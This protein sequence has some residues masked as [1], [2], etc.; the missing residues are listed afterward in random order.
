MSISNKCVDDESSPPA[1]EEGEVKSDAEAEEI[2]ETDLDSLKRELSNEISDLEWEFRQ[3]KEALYAERIAQVDKKLQQLKSSEAP[4]LIKVFAL[5]D[6]TYRIRK[7]VAKH[8]RD[9][10]LEV[11]NKEFDNALQMATYDA[12][13]NLRA[14]E[15]RLRLRIQ[16]NICSLQV[17]RVLA[18]RGMFHES[19]C[20]GQNLV[21]PS[22]DANF[23]RHQR[24]NHL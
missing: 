6:E 23:T 22:G 2:T 15:E 1:V 18:K 24:R 8:R 12:E 9:F 13:E 17:E 7:Q 14:T 3:I 4:E 11:A 16:E 19:S 10:E 21:L 20:V 5:V